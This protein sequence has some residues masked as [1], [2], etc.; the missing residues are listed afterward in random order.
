MKTIKPLKALIQTLGIF[1]LLTSLSAYAQYSAED[2]GRAVLPLPEELR[3]DATVYT[4][5]ENAPFII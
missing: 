3:A 2:I 5:D 4:Y 1:S